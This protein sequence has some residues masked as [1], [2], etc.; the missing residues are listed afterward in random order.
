MTTLTIDNKFYAIDLPA[1]RVQAWQNKLWERSAMEHSH[2]NHP[3]RKSRQ[4]EI[5]DVYASSILPVRETIK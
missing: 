4:Q 1:D 3:I 5:R 2:L